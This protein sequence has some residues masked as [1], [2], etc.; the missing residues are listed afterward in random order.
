VTQVDIVRGV[1]AMIP[2][3]LFAT[4]LSREMSVVWRRLDEL[5]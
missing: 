5:R 2:R 3:A 1:H 4:E